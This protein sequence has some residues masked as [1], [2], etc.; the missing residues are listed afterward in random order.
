M[1]WINNLIGDFIKTQVTKGAAI[2]AKAK[3]TKPTA[4]E[5]A[6]LVEENLRLQAALNAK[7]CD[8]VRLREGKFTDEELQNLC[9]N[10]DTKDLSAF[11]KGCENEQ[12][13]IFGRSLITEYKQKAELWDELMEIL[14]SCVSHIDD[15]QP[16][17]EALLDKVKEIKCQ[18]QID[19]AIS[20][21]KLN[22]KF[23]DTK[24]L[25]GM[26]PPVEENSEV[27]LARTYA[28]IREY[29]YKI[30]CT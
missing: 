24:N 12:I 18:K 22:I 10:L 8:N 14:F 4:E 20:A 23:I 28:E 30:Y 7:S 15:K 17:I 5:Y 13:K 11:C 1:F 3:K 29:I 25:W 27:F 21:Y 19:A 9:H 6:V 16:H 26:I 2:M